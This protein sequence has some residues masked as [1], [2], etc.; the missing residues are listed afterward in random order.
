MTQA[1]QQLA[2]GKEKVTQ[3]FREL[4]QGAEDLLR[5]ASSYSG[6]GADAVRAKLSTQVD[7][8]KN[9]A[10]TFETSASEKYR[11]LSE[12]TDG[13]VREKPWQAVGIAAVTGVVVG[14]LLARR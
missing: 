8:L 3:G 10:N 14:A 6:E 11:Q 5:S 12:S 1:A 13:Y 7:K 2:D 9:A 4:I